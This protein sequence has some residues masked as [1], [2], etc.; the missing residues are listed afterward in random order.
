MDGRLGL[1]ILEK[2][3]G[4]IEK[5][6][7]RGNVLGHLLRKVSSPEDVQRLKDWR[8]KMN[9]IGGKGGEGK[10]EEN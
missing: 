10:G 8:R 4:R 3:W 5:A 7:S 9:E 6:S 2:C 1:D